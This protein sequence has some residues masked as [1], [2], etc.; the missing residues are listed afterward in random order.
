MVVERKEWSP[1]STV[2][3]RLGQKVTF[4]FCNVEVTNYL[5]RISV[6]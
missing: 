5:K 4:G 2:V 3:E 6:I 1:A